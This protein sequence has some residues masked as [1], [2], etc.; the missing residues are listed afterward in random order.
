MVNGVPQVGDGVHPGA[1]SPNALSLGEGHWM[2][3]WSNPHPYPLPPLVGGGGA[4]H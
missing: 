4:Y 1:L 3:R 2:E